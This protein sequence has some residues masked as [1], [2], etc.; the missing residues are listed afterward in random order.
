[1]VI[2]QVRICGGPGRATAR[3]Y[4]TKGF[5]KQ[6]LVLITNYFGVELSLKKDLPRCFYFGNFTAYFVARGSV[7]DRA[8]GRKFA[9]CSAQASGKVQHG[10]KRPTAAG[11][12]GTSPEGG[13]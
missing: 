12:N 7:R 6:N 1:V 10:P 9:A 5:A 2:P 3:A 11:L 8:R 4:P 13:A